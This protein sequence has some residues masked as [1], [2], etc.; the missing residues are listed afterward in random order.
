MNAQQFNQQYPARSLFYYRTI[1]GQRV[2]R[3]TAPAHD[4][5]DTEPM[6][7]INRNPWF[8]PIKAL[9]IISIADIKQEKPGPFSTIGPVVRTPLYYLEF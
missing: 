1:H 6:V 3:T 5:G 8:V 4:C 9:H 7:E 2:V